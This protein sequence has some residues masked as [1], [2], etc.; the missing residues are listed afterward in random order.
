MKKVIFIISSIVFFYSCNNKPK[1]E[2]QIAADI[3]SNN[4]TL[5]EAQYK[6]A[7]IEIGKIDSKVISSTIKLNGKIDVPPQNMV[8]ISVPLGGYLK[9]TQLLPGMH[10]NKGEVL[11]V[12]EDPQYI[13]IQQDYLTAKAQFEY[14][15]SE[16][17]RQKELNQS[18]AASDKVFE[19]VK[20]TYQTQNIMIKALEQKLKLIGVNPSTITP[21]TISKSIQIHSPISGFVSSVNVNIGKYVTPSDVLFELVNPSDIHL[22]LTV[23]DKDL[24]KLSIGQKLVAYT[25]THPEKKYECEIILI[26]K[27]LNSDNSTQV[28]CH[29]KQYDKTLLPGMFMNAVVELSDTH[30]AVL[31]EDAI[32]HFENKNFVFVENGNKQFGMSEVQI[33]N[34]E[35]GFTEILNA[36]AF[37]G[38]KIAVKGA[39]SLLMA[40]KNVG[41]EEE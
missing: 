19:Q 9:S 17:L 16:Y 8:S 28:H 10:V 20:A 7:G 3:Q 1:A 6:N 18:K 30:T 22:A 40:L 21:N 4:V 29:F 32:V 2:Q 37:A 41:G 33:G 23:F 5:T 13:Q 15:E 39:Y 14:N 11:A 38:K 34:T 26:S 35:N 24:S 25:N 36:Q 27:S 31:P 12:M